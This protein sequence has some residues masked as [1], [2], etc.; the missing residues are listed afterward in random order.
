MSINKSGN[1]L[2]RW[3]PRASLAIVALLLLAACATPADPKHMAVPQ[4]S[5]GTGFPGALQ[6]AMCVR[7]VSGG[8]STNP[9][10]V[11]EV[12]NPEFREALTTSLSNAGLL[13]AQNSCKYFVDVNLL[14][15]SQPAAGFSMTVKSYAN[16]KVYDQAGNPILLATVSASYTAGVSDAFAG[17]VRLKDATEGAM[18]VSI[19]QF[20]DKL[21]NINIQPTRMPRS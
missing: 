10:W 16:Y 11:S 1:S 4:A 14:G 17:Y 19:S 6:H 2:A 5:I 18:R 15:V 12:G 21:R 3:F 9:L 7:S 20:L 13:S 8:E